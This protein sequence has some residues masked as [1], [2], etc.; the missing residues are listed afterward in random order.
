MPTPLDDNGRRLTRSMTN[1]IA[2]LVMDKIIFLV[3][4]NLFAFRYN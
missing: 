1:K 2:W 3:L 4:T